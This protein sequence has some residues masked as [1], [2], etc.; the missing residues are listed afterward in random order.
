METKNYITVSELNYYLYRTIAAEELLQNIP[1]M[2]EV[3]GLSIAGNHLY[4]TV[5]DEGAQIAAC[6]FHFKKSSYLPA[7][8]EQ[9][10]LFGSP[11]YYQ[12]GGKLSFVVNRIEPFGKGKLFAE[13]E[14]LRQRLAGEGLFDAARKR[15]L[16]RF[17][18]KVGIVTSLSGAVIYD[19]VRTFRKNN[20]ITDLTCINVPV[21]GEGAVDAICEGLRLADTQGFDAIILA[22]GGG[23][24]EDLMPFNDEKTVRA[25]GNMRTV[26][27]CAVGHETDYSLCDFAADAR[28]MTPTAAAEMLS[29]NAKELAEQIVEK[30]IR[31]GAMVSLRTDALY[32][33]VKSRT[34][35][36]RHICSSRLNAYA[37]KIALRTQK[38]MRLADARMTLAE[39]RTESLLAKLS[40]LNPAAL[41]QKGY[42]RAMKDGKDVRRIG[43]LVCGDIFR[44]YGADG[45]LDAEVLSTEYKETL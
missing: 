34:R 24:S 18:L 16:P 25:V 31:A 13:L 39:R 10:L 33:K 17:P 9:V 7:E 14:K 20:K 42:F 29:F 28:A 26:T 27:V 3:S 32:Q 1:V 5:K 44:L 36:V 6:F 43:D 30:T 2:G 38:A 35:D 40:A 19:I 15:P 37:Q 41:L 12:K 8:G 22:R 4:F 23:S 21:Q 45:T 11:E